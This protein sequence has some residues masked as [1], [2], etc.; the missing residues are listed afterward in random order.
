MS[1]P[2]A[3][4]P[5][6][7]EDLSALSRRGALSATDREAFE[8][9]LGSDAEIATAHRIGC[10]FDRAAEV[11]A[12]DAALIARLAKRTVA[13]T[14]ER[15]RRP[16]SRRR[17]LAVALVATLAIAGSSAAAWRQS[18]IGRVVVSPAK[19]LPA[20]NPIGKAQLGSSRAEPSVAPAVEPS[21]S[22][23]AP[24]SPVALRA[25]ASSAAVASRQPTLDAERLFREANAARHAGDLAGAR[26]LYLRLEREFPDTEEA[27][28]AHVSLGKLL[29]AMGRA[30]EAERQFEGYLAGRQELAEEALF[31]RA[32]SLAELDSAAEEQ[33]VWARLLREYPNSVYAGRARQRLA[34]LSRS[35]QPSP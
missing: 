6:A 21:A 7:A 3:R 11:R 17:L 15:K 28:L 27:R 26:A 2:K 24:P 20:G 13:R 34:E 9:V 8:R 33:R 4:K 19:S 10:D 31:G 12:G 14:P 29:L 1:Q 5:H 18:R 30:Q 35:Q 23:K 22:S 25:L 32:Q 16:G